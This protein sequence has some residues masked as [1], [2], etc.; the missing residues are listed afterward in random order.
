MQDFDLPNS[1]MD[2][3]RNIRSIEVCPDLKPL[4]ES[5]ILN[6]WP[7]LV[8]IDSERAV[9]GLGVPDLFIVG[10]RAKNDP[11]QRW[12]PSNSQSYCLV[13]HSKNGFGLWQ[14]ADAS[15]PA[16]KMES[17]IGFLILVMD[18]VLA[19]KR[20]DARKRVMAK[21]KLTETICQLRKRDN[22]LVAAEHL[23]QELN[24]KS[25][26]IWN[27]GSASFRIWPKHR[28]G[29]DLMGLFS[30]GPKHQGFFSIDVSG[31]GLAAAL[32]CARIA[33]GFVG[34]CPDT[35]RALE[36]DEGT[37]V[38]ADPATVVEKLNNQMFDHY[39]TDAYFTF[40]LGFIE[41]ET[42]VITI[43]S[44]GHPPPIFFGPKNT[45]KSIEFYGHPVGLVPGAEYETKTLKLE[46]DARMLLYS[47]GIS[48]AL[49]QRHG[50]QFGEAEIFKSLN[51]LH[52][53]PD[54]VFLDS[55]YDAVNWF[56]GGNVFDDACGM[57]INFQSSPK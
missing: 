21:S 22:D 50:I 18:A 55:L 54:G 33:G 4:I 45:A 32:L 34:N 44:A 27:N 2:S 6:R 43:C 29:G 24:A 51:R 41:Y 1:K 20:R 57:V 8:L 36:K 52:A 25:N 35:N 42:G 11:S 30:A 10:E 53:K 28:V 40:S 7:N 38:P 14:C 23:Q 16:H 49:S 46:S 5:A 19:K 39:D 9:E 3:L 48:E 17:E 31:H 26:S 47:D 12:K 13:V 56:C 15:L 37:I